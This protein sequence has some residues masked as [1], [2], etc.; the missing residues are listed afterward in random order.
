VADC[1]RTLTSWRP[2]REEWDSRVALNEIRKSAD[3]GRFDPKV[4]E[5]LDAVLRSGN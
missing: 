5:V 4:V 2:Y 1:Y 3:R